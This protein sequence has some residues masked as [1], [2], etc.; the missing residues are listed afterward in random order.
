MGAHTRLFLP[1]PGRAYIEFL[2]AIPS[3]GF[4]ANQPAAS[5]PVWVRLTDADADAED[6]DDQ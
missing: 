5:D 3:F 1:T 4:V 6:G 2:E